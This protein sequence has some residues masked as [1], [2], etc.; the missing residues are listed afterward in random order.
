VR[1][2][3]SGIGYPAQRDAAG[4]HY[5]GPGVAARWTGIAHGQYTVTVAHQGAWVGLRIWS[6]GGQWRAKVDGR[7]VDPKPR[8]VGSDSAVHTIGLDFSHAQP[9]KRRVVRFELSGGAWLAGIVAGAHDRLGLPPRASGP[10]AYWL[11]DSYFAGGGAR[12]PGFTD[13]VHRAS[14]R[15]GWSQVTVDALGDTGYVRDNGA[16]KFPNFLAR[17][18]ANIGKGRA[19]PDVIVIGGSINDAGED[20]RAVRA[21]AR[22]L[23]AYL[24][25]AVPAAKVVVVVFSPRIPAPANF[26]ALDKAV[27]D[28][29]AASPNVAGALDL[30][31]MVPRTAG[32][33]QG[34]N[35]HPTQSGHDL[36]GGL[37]ADFIRARIRR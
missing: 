26:A 11:G 27:L 34:A 17:A 14:A 20:L 28:A 5:V 16:A 31:S 29:A 32:R 21:S 13:L 8:P 1:A 37:I 2:R 22:R 36:Y 9:S 24:S 19:Q 12:Y 23:Y 3:L 10:S 30:P 7:Y 18:R 25:R 15:L 33:V 6:R 4:T 35:G